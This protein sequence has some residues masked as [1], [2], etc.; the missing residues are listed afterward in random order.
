M[1]VVGR[2]E[3]LAA[4]RTLLVAGAPGTGKTTLFPARCDR[5]FEEREF[6]SAG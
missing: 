5:N 6:E 1:D 3:E 4:L 2:D